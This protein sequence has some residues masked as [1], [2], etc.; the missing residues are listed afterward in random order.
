MITKINAWKMILPNALL[1][2]WDCN[3]FIKSKL[4]QIIKTNSKPTKYC[5]KK[6]K[7]KAKND[8]IKKN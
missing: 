8:L 7:E 5:K 2:V 1:F 4:K 6:M 3:N